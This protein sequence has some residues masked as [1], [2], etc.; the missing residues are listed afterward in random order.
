MAN[1]VILYSGGSGMAATPEEQQKIMADWGAWYGKLGAAIVDGGS[2]FAASKHYRGPGEAGDGPLGDTPA[3]GYTIIQA[4]S[5]DAATALCADHPHL[6]HGGQVQVFE[7][8]D[9]GGD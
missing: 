8:L 3:T 2:P 9:M 7:G 4:D 5:L 6:S 1:F